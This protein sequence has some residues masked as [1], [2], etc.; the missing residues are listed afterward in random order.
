[1]QW[2]ADQCPTP[3]TYSNATCP[4]PVV[5]V[6]GTMYP[7]CFG[8]DCAGYW[9]P[10]K[11]Y[12]GRQKGTASLAIVDSYTNPWLQLDLGTLVSDIASVQLVARA[13]CKWRTAHPAVCWTMRTM[14]SS[15]AVLLLHA[16]EAAA[17]HRGAT[18]VL[19][20][21]VLLWRRL[22]EPVPE[23]VRVPQQVCTV[24]AEEL[25]LPEA[26]PEHWRA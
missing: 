26:G 24:A 15:L 10:A 9:G 17:A 14:Q 21:P 5:P 16:H 12:D 1:M 3:P 6:R 25:A 2:S 23:P 19:L 8:G 13:D 22:P 18:P 4:V 20:C 11:A 7:S